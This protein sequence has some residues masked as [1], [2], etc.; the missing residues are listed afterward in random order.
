MNSRTILIA[1]ALVG[2]FT[3]PTVHSAPIIKLD[4]SSTVFP[5]S[6][7]A[8]E[9]FQLQQKGK[10]RIT[11]GISGTGGGFKKFC[12][13]EI[14]IANASRPI[15]PS[16]VEK[17]RALGIEF[18]ELP[19]AFDG[20]VVVVHPDNNWL[21]AI[22]VADLKKIWEPAAQGT[23]THWNHVRPEWPNAKIQLF[24]AGSDSGTFEYFTEAVV[25]KSKSSRGD[26]TAS[27]DD[28]TL[29]QGVSQEKG[30]LGYLPM[31]YYAENKDRLKALGIKSTESGKPVFPSPQS[32]EDGSYA[33]LS[34]PVFIYANLERLNQRPQIEQFLKFYLREAKR[35]VP[36]A[37]YVAFP[38][39]VYQ[40][41]EKR[42]RDRTTGSLFNGH[43]PTGFSI[44]KLL[45]ESSKPDSSTTSISALKSTIFRTDSSQT[46]QLNLELQTE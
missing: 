11:V 46:A 36:E 25:G 12:R 41:A 10:A 5:I 31:A 42:L 43:L 38:D 33:P 8:A 20:T 32:I 7:A 17:C 28:N 29:I 22:S 30:S 19:V 4:G 21:D 34:R 26:Y 15:H 1:F 24:G 18:I 13:G 39:R 45:S 9:D 27:E 3:G 2:L 14:D 16:E 37:K 23:I 6:E 40:L 44:E 35:L